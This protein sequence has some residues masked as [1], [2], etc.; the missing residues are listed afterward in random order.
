ME[1]LTEIFTD[2]N[3]LHVF[4]S[5]RI[6]GEPNFSVSYKARSEILEGKIVTYPVILYESAH[7]LHRVGVLL[8]YSNCYFD[9]GAGS[10]LSRRSC[11][12]IIGLE[13]P[14]N[15]IAFELR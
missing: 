9:N 7:R 2:S 14:R 5:V 4:G 12:P 3:I 15:T 10:A 8:I 6:S 11:I 1:T 13:R